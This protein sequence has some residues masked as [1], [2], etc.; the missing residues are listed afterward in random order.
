MGDRVKI[1]CIAQ[2]VNVIAPIRTERGGKAWTTTIYH[3]FRLASLYG[4][5]RAL[6]VAIDGPTYEC[7]V[8]SDVSYLDAAA[9]LAKDGRTL[10]LF[11]LNRHLTEAMDLS[12]GLTG[13]AKLSLV[14]HVVI[15][16]KGVS[17]SS[18]VSEPA[19]WQFAQRATK[20]AG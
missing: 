8:A 15:G 6:D 3:P 5:G 7:E 19:R 17:A 14:E 12:V 2:L 20:V 9:V 10:T 18:T 11:I 16:G 4:R 13:F 1:A